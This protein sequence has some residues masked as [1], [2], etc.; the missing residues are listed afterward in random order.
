[1]AAS[2][3][4]I[5]KSPCCPPGHSALFCASSRHS[6]MPYWEIQGVFCR[7]EVVTVEVVDMDA[8]RLQ[9]EVLDFAQPCPAAGR[10][11]AAP[12]RSV[13]GVWILARQHSYSQWN[14]KD[15]TASSHREVALRPFAAG[16]IAAPPIVALAISCVET[17]AGVQSR[18]HAILS[19]ILTAT[20]HLR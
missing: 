9:Q 18:R 8:L 4:E 13:E 14:G 7:A 2:L 19:T 15:N 1:M 3:V 5:R 12:G 16:R 11:T 10:I 17:G 6:L 20:T